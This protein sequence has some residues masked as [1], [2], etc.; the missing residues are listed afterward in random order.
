MEDLRNNVGRLK[1]I[2][3][4]FEQNPEKRGRTLDSKQDF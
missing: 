3:D 1:N 2:V 4:R